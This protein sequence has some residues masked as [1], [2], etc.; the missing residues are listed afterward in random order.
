[1]DGA[2]PR[3]AC[4]RWRSITALVATTAA[5]AASTL[6][7]APWSWWWLTPP[8][9]AVLFLN[10]WRASPGRAFLLGYLFGLGLFG[11]GVAWVHVS[12]LRYGSG[13]ALASFAA[14][15][16]LIALLAAFP[17]LALF[18]A[19]SLRPQSAPWALWAAMPAAWVALEW[20]RTWIFTGFPWLPI[21]YSQTDSP[22]AVGL[23]PVA[24]VLG[25][26]AS[27]ALL[28]AALVWC[29]DAADWRRGGATAVAVVALGAAIHF[30]LAR[31]WTQ[32]AG[33]PL[34]VA[35]VQGNF[36]QAEKWRPE[37]RSKTLSRYAA[38]SEPFWQ[39]DLIVWPETALPQPYDSLP[40]GYADRLAKRV[41]ETDT[42]LILGAPTRRDGRMFNSAIAVGEDTAY[43][44]RHLVPF[45]EYVP[46]RGLFGN[47]LDVLG[48]PESDFT[49]GSK[50]TLLPVAGY[51]GGIAICCEIITCC[52]RPIPV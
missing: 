6:A 34:E 10:A 16:G 33:A 30:G 29:A 8:C 32:P 39:A 12:M 40:A 37:N 15:G 22:L 25:L 19:R 38:L 4:R 51:R 14:T 7:F 44:K 23:A 17:G 28:A 1:M 49:S 46:L 21:G 13:G 35:L 41:H 24:G 48:A 20:V 45:G 43:H 26:S 18:V 11:F 2:F 31:D 36:D 5:G 27:A 3:T 52:G 42:A 50:S 47:L 9:L